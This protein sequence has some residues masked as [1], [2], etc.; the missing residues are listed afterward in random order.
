[1]HTFTERFVKPVVV[2]D[3]CG[4][5]MSLPCVTM[6]NHSSLHA[7]DAVPSAAF[8]FGRSSSRYNICRHSV[9]LTLH[10]CVAVTS[11]AAVPSRP[12]PPSRHVRCCCSVR[13][14]VRLIRVAVPRSPSL[15]VIE[16][17]A[18]YTLRR[19]FV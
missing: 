7:S 5:K 9:R 4:T 19:F 6:C 2:R 3:V 1:M 11:A 18:A 14:F 12:L 16:L 17:Y 15:R 10:T 8:S 13:S